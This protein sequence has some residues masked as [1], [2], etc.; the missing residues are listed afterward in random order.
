MGT[1]EKDPLYTSYPFRESEV[2]QCS[3]NLIRDKTF[4]SHSIWLLFCLAE[5]KAAFS[6]AAAAGDYGVPLSPQKIGALSPSRAITGC[7]A[8]ESDPRP[9]ITTAPITKSWGVGFLQEEC[10]IFAL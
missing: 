6:G 2:V 8:I 5:R 4:C 9:T 10:R 3:G 1:S 7:K